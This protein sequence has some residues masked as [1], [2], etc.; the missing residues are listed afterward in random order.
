MSPRE[1]VRLLAQAPYSLV[2]D[3]MLIP[4]DDLYRLM[5]MISEMSAQSLTVERVMNRLSSGA[6]FDAECSLALEQVRRI[7]TVGSTA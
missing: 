4:R 2:A 1:A 5:A 6:P 7:L 3:R